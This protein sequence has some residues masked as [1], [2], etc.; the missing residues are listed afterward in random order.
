MIAKNRDGSD[1]VK[2]VDFGIAKAAGAENQKVTKTGL[3]VGTPEYM[4]PEQ[5][6]GDKL[7]GRSDVY[8]LAL[9][10]FNMLTGKLP[11][12]GETAQES[13]IM[14][15][16]DEPRSLQAVKPDTNW[17]ADVQAVMHKALQRK[18]ADRYQKASEFG[19]A[20]WQAVERMPAARRGSATQMIGAMDGATA[21][22]VAP[23][24]TR[25]DPGA[26][27]VPPAVVA[28]V[29][30]VAVPVP[31]SKMPVYAGSGAVAIALAALAF[32]YFP[33]AADK[34]GGTL[35]APTNSNVPAATTVT[36][37]QTTPQQTAAAPGTPAQNDVAKNGGK[38]S[39]PPVEK[40]TAAPPTTP[41]PSIS[42]RLPA[43]LEESD[44]PDKAAAALR[45][46]TALQAKAVS[47]NDVIGLSLVRAK[48]VGMLGKDTE[49]C[50]ILHTIKDRSAETP[51]GEKVT[52]LLKLSCP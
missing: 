49:S 18:A 6:A 42:D 22:V 7:D 23:P 4:S 3:V 19:V 37:P 8:S 25:V 34:T 5:L 15:L 16:T 51:Y 24:K 46:A 50:N 44:D 35:P 36:A 38:L 13:M 9:V 33:K 26:A 14:R 52:Q 40:G 30:P 17:T 31:R 10:A 47:R 12:E 41:T 28:P 20:L 2:V 1:C 27:A 11:F 39:T 21:L 48:A 32:V 43:L 45:D 29:Q